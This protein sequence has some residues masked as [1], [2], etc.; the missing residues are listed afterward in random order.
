MKYLPINIDI[1]DCLLKEQLEIINYVESNKIR[2]CI[3]DYEDKDESKITLGLDV[4]DL[5]RVSK[6]NPLIGI[7]EI[8]GNMDKELFYFKVYDLVFRIGDC[9]YYNRGL[10]NYLRPGKKLELVNGTTRYS[11]KSITPDAFDYLISPISDNLLW[12]MLVGAFRDNIKLEE[13]IFNQSVLK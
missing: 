10:S 11:V 3:D 9:R 5:A 6:E 8:I 12:D 13:Y 2:Y 1:Q 4:Y 7:G